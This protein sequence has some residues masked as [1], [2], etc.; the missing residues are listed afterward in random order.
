LAYL[1]SE[2]QLCA[3]IDKIVIM[4]SNGSLPNI[5]QLSGNDFTLSS[6]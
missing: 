2:K 4:L 5:Q 3:W 1:L 6:D